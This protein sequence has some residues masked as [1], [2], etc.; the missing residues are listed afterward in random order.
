MSKQTTK[1]IYERLEALKAA[2]PNMIWQW[3]NTNGINIGRDERTYVYLKCVCPESY[4]IWTAN[5]ATPYCTLSSMSVLED[6]LYSI[7]GA[8]RKVSCLE[9]MDWTRWDA[10]AAK[11]REELARLQKEVD[12]QCEAANRPLTDEEYRQLVNA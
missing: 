7:M 4:C 3:H 5:T 2:H 10:V 12:A 11:A 9:Q 1:S 8:A 6:G